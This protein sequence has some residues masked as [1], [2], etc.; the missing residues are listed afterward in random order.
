MPLSFASDSRTPYA[1]K[2]FEPNRA[3]LEAI[4]ESQRIK[5]LSA[6]EELAA[7]H[8]RVVS[9]IEQVIASAFP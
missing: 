6:S 8:T 5:A 9:A 4:A 3:V 2:P 1:P 7:Q